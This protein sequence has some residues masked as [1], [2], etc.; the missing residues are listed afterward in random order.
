ME[1]TG[2][3]DRYAAAGHAPGDAARVAELLAPS[4]E[5]AGKRP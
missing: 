4:L 3:L 2:M 1:G 5:R